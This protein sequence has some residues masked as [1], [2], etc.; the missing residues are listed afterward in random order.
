MKIISHPKQL[1]NELLELKKQG[2]TIAFVPTMGNLHAGH[3][4]LI[5]LAKSKAD[6]VVCSIFVNPL[7]FDKPSDL[8]NYP[9]TFDS[10]K[11]KL[12]AINTDYLFTPSD[13]SIYPQGKKVHTSVEA[14]RLTQSLCGATRVGHFLG[15][16]TVVNILFNIV[17]PNVAIFGKK[18]YQQLLVIQA[19][20]DDLMMPIKVIGG[21][22]KREKN[23]LAMSSRNIHLTQSEKNHASLLRQ[24][25]LETTDNIKQHMSLE[26]AQQIAV[27]KLNNNGFKVDYFEIVR[28]SDLAEA[29]IN[30]KDLLIA[31]AAWLGQPRL[32]DNLEIER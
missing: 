5:E 3:L 24:V 7:Q 1:Q 25:I 29:E 28:R 20:V 19:M 6:I 26:K 12:E 21:D 15:V 17:Q 27:N 23:G 30:D 2:K 31:A 16:T 13:S 10:D 8:E 14:H 32:I 11:N 4:S 22:T 18:D 9:R